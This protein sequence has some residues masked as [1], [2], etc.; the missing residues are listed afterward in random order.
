MYYDYSYLLSSSLLELLIK[1]LKNKTIEYLKYLLH[2]V[3]KKCKLVSWSH[4]IEWFKSNWPHCDIS[5]KLY[6]LIKILQYYYFV[7]IYN[8]IS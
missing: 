4:F 5:A 2:R 8:I 1:N 3:Y 6:S 7:I